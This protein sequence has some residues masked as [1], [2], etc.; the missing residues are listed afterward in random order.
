MK[1]TIKRALA[2]LA[3]STMMIAMPM[4]A[5]AATKEDV[6]AAARGAGF[7][8]EYVQMLQNYLNVT[9]FTES[10]YDIMVDKLYSAG[11]EFDKVA[12]QYF[13]KTVAQLKGQGVED[14]NT[15]DNDDPTS[16]TTPNNVDPGLQKKLAEIASHLTDDQKEKIFKELK[17]AGKEMGV[18]ISFEK[19]GEKDYIMTIKD[20]DGNVQLVTPIGKLVDTT[21][22]E[23]EDDDVSAALILAVLG[24]SAALGC[25]GAYVIAAIS[26]KKED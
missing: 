12:M 14:D 15:Q 10:Q 21:G 7:L 17:D 19:K 6:V 26:K 25:A 9:P 5:S 8:E 11:S 3:A 24:G 22:A 1:F 23:E 18:D 16:P 13:G 20:K 2:A 4:S